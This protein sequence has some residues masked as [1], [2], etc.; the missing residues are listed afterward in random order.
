M[1]RDDVKDYCYKVQALEKNTSAYSYSTVMCLHQEPLVFIPNVF[2]P[3]N[4][5][6]LNDVFAPKGSYIASYEMQ[7]YNRWGEQIF[8]G[9]N[10]GWDGT[11]HSKKVAEGVYLY[12]IT[13]HSF[14]GT[15]QLIKGN[16]TIIS[17][18]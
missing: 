1:T 9:E 16:V 15:S 14:N 5:D 7:V 10:K 6:H 8:S 2:T 11:F 3:M 12:I 4:D 18:D 13:V 17:G